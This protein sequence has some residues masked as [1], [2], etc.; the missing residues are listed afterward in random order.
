MLLSWLLH[1]AAPRQRN[2]RAI[3]TSVATLDD[4]EETPQTWQQHGSHPGTVATDLRRSLGAGGEPPWGLFLQQEA[5]ASWATENGLW[6]ERRSIGL[7]SES[8]GVEHEITF[9][10]ARQRFIKITQPGSYG[11]VGSC[12]WGKLE[13]VQAKP[14]EYLDRLAFS[15]DLFG[16]GTTVL[17]AIAHESGLRIVTAQPL[18][19]GTRP[20]GEDIISWMHSLGFAAAGQKT[21]WNAAEGLA[22]FDAHPGNVLKV[23]GGRLCPIDIIPCLADAPMRSFLNQKAKTWAKKH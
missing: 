6:I 10:E 18:I 11:H 22:I 15:D 13:L 17:G 3:P 12:R 14:L 21:Y 4:N 9:D 8:P 7:R 19:V 23:P 20:S 1:P 5:L 2:P 16:D